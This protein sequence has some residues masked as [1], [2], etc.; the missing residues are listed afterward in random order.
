VVTLARGGNF[1]GSRPGTTVVACTDGYR[2]VI[3][4]LERLERGEG[5]DPGLGET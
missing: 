2:P 3:F 4:G 1:H 5:P